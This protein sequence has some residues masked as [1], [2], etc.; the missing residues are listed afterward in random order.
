[1]PVQTNLLLT[2]ILDDPVVSCCCCYCH[3]ESCNKDLRSTYNRTSLT[4]AWLKMVLLLLLLLLLAKVIELWLRCSSLV[5]S[6]TGLGGTIRPRRLQ[7][8]TLP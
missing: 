4:R 2:L 7:C 3:V 1:M 8:T 6:P 5:R